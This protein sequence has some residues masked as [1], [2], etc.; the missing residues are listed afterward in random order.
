[1][2]NCHCHA[3]GILGSSKT[4]VEEELPS[5]PHSGCEPVSSIEGAKRS[6]FDWINKSWKTSDIPSQDKR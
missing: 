4:Y 2:E 3:I 6:T 5:V 1:M